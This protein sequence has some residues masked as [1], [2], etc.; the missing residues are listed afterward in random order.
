MRYRKVLII[1]AVL[2]LSGLLAIQVNAGPKGQGKGKGPKPPAP[3]P[4]TGQTTSYYPGDDGDLQ[5]GVE[6]PD[7]RFTDNEDGTV[8]DNLTGLIW[9]EDANC[10][11][12]SYSTFDNDGTAADGRVTWYHA[13]DFI[14]GINDGTYTDCGAGY[15]DWH[16]ANVNEYLSLMDY[17]VN[18]PALMVGHPFAN[19]QASHYWSSTMSAG[20]GT[21]WWVYFGGGVGTSTPGSNNYYVWPV[22]GGD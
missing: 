14:A 3:V 17:S 6:W 8:T 15:T 20:G 9:L 22:R 11:A 7:P 18:A 5:K 4:Q 13:L 16:L 1:L 10:I 19:V 12:S 21:V 2:I